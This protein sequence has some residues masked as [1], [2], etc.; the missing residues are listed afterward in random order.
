[1]PGLNGHFDKSLPAFDHNKWVLSASE[2]PLP[3]IFKALSYSYMSFNYEA[4][5]VKTQ[6]CLEWQETCS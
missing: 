3:S 1:M 4:V 5:S 2:C 6:R